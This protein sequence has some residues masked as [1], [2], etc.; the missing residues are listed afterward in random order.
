MNNTRWSNKHLKSRFPYRRHSCCQKSGRWC[1]PFNILSYQVTCSRSLENPL[2]QCVGGARG[3]ENNWKLLP[4]ILLAWSIHERLVEI[5]ANVFNSCWKPSKLQIV[6][7]LL[8]GFYFDQVHKIRFVFCIYII[9][10]LRNVKGHSTANCCCGRAVLNE[11][12]LQYLGLYSSLIT[13]Y[14]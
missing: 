11:H 14:F 9:L 5:Q 13:N 3:R 6:T 7:H 10:K 2:E 4:S 8:T 12:V 1:S